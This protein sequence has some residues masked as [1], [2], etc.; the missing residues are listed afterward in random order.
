MHEQAPSVAPQPA[1]PVWQRVQYL[2]PWLLVSFGATLV[3][4][5]ST[6]FKPVREHTP[7]AWLRTLLTCPMCFGWWVGFALGWIHFGPAACLP[8]P[9]WAQTLANG[10]ASSGW[11]WILHVMLVHFGEDKL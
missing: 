5:R 2:A 10:F 8:W 9:L 6:I 1:P 3:V 11:C 7:T 4:T